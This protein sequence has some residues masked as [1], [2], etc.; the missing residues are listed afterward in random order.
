M[1]LMLASGWPGAPPTSRND[2]ALLSDN[3]PGCARR[4]SESFLPVLTLVLCREIGKTP[5]NQFTFPFFP[6]LGAAVCPSLG[7]PPSGV[8]QLCWFQQRQPIED[9]GRVW[10]GLQPHH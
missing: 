10:K 7:G 4:P 9:A 6:A 3:S 5:H 2:R 8:I 1:M